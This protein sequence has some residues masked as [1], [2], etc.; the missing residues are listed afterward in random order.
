MF[1]WLREGVSWHTG[2]NKWENHE[3]ITFL[4]ETGPAVVETGQQWKA[5]NAQY[6]FFISV[7]PVRHLNQLQCLDTALRD[8][9][10]SIIE[11]QFEYYCRKH[12]FLMSSKLNCWDCQTVF[13][14]KGSCF[15]SND[16][17]Y[18]YSHS[19]T[20][21]LRMQLPTHKSKHQYFERS[22]ATLIWVK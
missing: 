4:F 3:S 1:Y 11:Q 17:F 5:L 6:H 13:I 21:I 16:T 20:D 22:N 18:S 2:L 12:R 9:E 7:I 8:D 15:D 10:A 14:F 19:S